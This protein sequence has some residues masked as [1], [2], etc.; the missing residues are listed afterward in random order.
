M[1]WILRCETWLWDNWT[2]TYDNRL[3]IQIFA[4]MKNGKKQIKQAAWHGLSPR[5]THYPTEVLVFVLC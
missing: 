4:F 2:K 5:Q 3:N 1:W